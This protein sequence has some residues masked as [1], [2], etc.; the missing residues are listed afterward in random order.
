LLFYYFKF[1]IFGRDV[2]SSTL[3]ID[4]DVLYHEYILSVL[5]EN[6]YKIFVILKLLLSY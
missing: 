5:Y 3:S 4:K 2:T 1:V 6:N